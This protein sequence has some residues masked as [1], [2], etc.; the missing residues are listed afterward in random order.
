MLLEGE[1]QQMDPYTKTAEILKTGAEAADLHYYEGWLYYST[2][3]AVCRLNPGT[4]REEVFC[5]RQTGKLHIS[6]RQ[7]YLHDDDETGYLYRINPEDRSLTQL[8]GALECRC[9]NIVGEKLFYI[10]PDRG[11]SIYSCDLDGGS[12]RLI[13]GSSYDSLCVHAGKL[14]AAG[15]NGLIRMDLDGADPERLSTLPASCP[16]VT[17][18][19]VFYVSGRGR[20]LEWLSPDGRTGYTVV[21]TATGSFNVAGQWIFYHNDDDGG[22]LWRVRVNGSDAARVTTAAAD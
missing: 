5:D 18:G 11:N 17:D 8:N 21:P 12:S 14:Y 2:A 19:G 9:L 16:N 6:G 3:E 15:G 10:A 20:S 22:R 7:F 13:S 1:I 4:G